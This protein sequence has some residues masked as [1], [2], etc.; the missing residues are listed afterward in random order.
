MSDKSDYPDPEK[1]ALADKLNLET[2]KLSWPE[3]QRHF[4][5]GMVIVV[6]TELDLIDVAIKLT[7]DDKAQFETW[8]AE[9][10]VWR[11]H[12]EDAIHWQETDPVF[13]SVVVAPWVLVQTIQSANS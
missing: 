11:A 7:E 2:G 13:W 10:K 1:L 9:N 4:A 6:G 12:D 3:L 8:T 5:R